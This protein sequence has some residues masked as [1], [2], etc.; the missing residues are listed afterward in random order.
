MRR[1][2]GKAHAS[3]R[4]VGA[5]EERWRLV[6]ELRHSR[7]AEAHGLLHL[8]GI[9]PPG[10]LDDRVHRGQIRVVEQEGAAELELRS[11]VPPVEDR[12][13]KPVRAVDQHEIERTRLQRARTS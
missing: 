7:G 2:V 8:P 13:G 6:R 12:I 11:D 5:G 4:G 9:A 10:E 1:E 3:L